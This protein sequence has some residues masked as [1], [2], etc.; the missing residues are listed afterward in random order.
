M[1]II[2]K[3]LEKMR[4]N[5]YI[6]FRLINYPLLW[7]NNVS[8]GKKLRVFGMLQIKCV[9]GTITIG[10]NVTINSSTWSNPI[11][12]G[13]RTQFQTIG[14][15]RIT[16]GNSVGISNAAI[17]S[18]SEVKI[19]NNVLIGA[20]VRIY[21]TDFHSIDP[22]ERINERLDSILKKPIIIEDNVFVGAGSIILKGV[23]IGKNSVVGAGSIV[24]KSIPPN[25]VWAGN[26]AKKIHSL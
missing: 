12:G 25:E 21:D 5:A 24:T 1:L 18:A 14:H 2:R 22:T 3:V 15:G 13:T 8:V 10:D 16:I 26:P 11:G 19:G 4:N 20:G 7:I 23:T 6:F 17:T 9:H